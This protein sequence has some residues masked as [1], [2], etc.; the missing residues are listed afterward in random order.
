MKKVII[1]AGVFVTTL[2]AVRRFG[3]A[4]H[5]WCM[6]KC[7]NMLDRMPRSSRTAA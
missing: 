5:E 3:P 1:G 4:L 7:Q 6:T 2:V